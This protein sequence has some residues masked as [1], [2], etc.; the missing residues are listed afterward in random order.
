MVQNVLTR[1]SLRA[2]IFATALLLWCTV[3]AAPIKVAAQTDNDDKKPAVQRPSDDM[4]AVA[5]KKNES[6][7]TEGELQNFDQFLDSHPQIASDLKK[8]P[9]LIDDQNYLNSHPQLAEFLKTHPGVREQVKENPQRFMNR[10]L[11]YQASGEGVKPEELRHFDEFLDKH[12]QIAQDLQ[13]NPA[14]ANDPSYLSSHP[15]LKKFLDGYGGVRHELKTRPQEFMEQFR[16]YE[17][18]ED[19]SKPRK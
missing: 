7:I 13:K 11:G 14:L 10:E 6:H 3:L 5:Q 17:K 4:N 8:N 19:Q 18:R 16:K 2:T 9:S 1:H 15:E 12:P